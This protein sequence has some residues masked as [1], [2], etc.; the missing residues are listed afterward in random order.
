MN[1]VMPPSH[2]GKVEIDQSTVSMD[3]SENELTIGKIYADRYDFSNKE[4]EIRGV[5]VKVND[6]IMSRNWV[7]IQDGTSD[8]GNFDLTIT[9]QAQVKVGDEVTFKGKIELD[10][11]FTSGYFYDVIMIDAELLS[12]KTG[13][14]SM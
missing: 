4:T 2:S 10:K 3:K 11:D 12:L 14:T 8:N 9:T 5:V 1:P 6:G 7:H 13:G